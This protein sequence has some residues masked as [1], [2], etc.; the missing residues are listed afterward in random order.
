ML[1]EIVRASGKC[2]RTV[3]K[4]LWLSSWPND[5]QAQC[6]VHPTIFTTRVLHNSFASKSSYWSEREFARLRIEVSRMIEKGPGSNPRKPYS[7]RGTSKGSKTELS[8][9]ERMNA[10]ECDLRT[11]KT[12]KPEDRIPTLFEQMEAQ[13][14]LRQ[15]L[16]TQVKVDGKEI[17]VRYFGA[18]DL[19]RIL[20]SF[21]K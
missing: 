3:Q 14:I 9:A 13:E 20:S 10:S 12:A 16:S 7:K 5:L 17:R 6:A 19:D 1:G 2:R 11:E 4:A 21:L 15:A 18:G 8:P